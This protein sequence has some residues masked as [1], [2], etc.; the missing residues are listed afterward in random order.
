[1]KNVLEG[2]E[3]RGQLPQAKGSQCL[4]GAMPR[5]GAEKWSGREGDWGDGL[6]EHQV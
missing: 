6:G 2:N 1:M 4:A 5:A 3:N